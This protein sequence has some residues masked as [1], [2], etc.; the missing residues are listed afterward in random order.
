MLY[1]AHV[2]YVHMHEYGASGR[3]AVKLKI[4]LKLLSVNRRLISFLFLIC[5]LSLTR[6]Q[7]LSAIEA[8][9]I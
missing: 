9:Y 6:F 4:V 2:I 1:H 3:L 5:F 7:S 8:K